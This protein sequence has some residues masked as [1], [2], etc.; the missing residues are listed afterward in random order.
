MQGFIGESR[1][2]TPALSSASRSIQCQSGRAVEPALKFGCRDKY[3]P[4][5]T[6]ETQ[7]RLYVTI[8]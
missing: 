8:E 2:G 3:E 5:T 1:L 6:N 4:T 7:L